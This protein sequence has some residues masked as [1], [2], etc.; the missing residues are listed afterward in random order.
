MRA[1]IGAERDAVAVD[2]EVAAEVAAVVEHLRRH[3]LAAVVLFAFV[4]LQRTAQPVV[5]ADVE[6]EHQEDRGL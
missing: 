6:V 1:W 2:V 3:H 4:P 5:H